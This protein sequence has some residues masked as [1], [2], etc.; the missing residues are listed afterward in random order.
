MVRSLRSVNILWSHYSRYWDLKALCKADGDNYCGIQ[1]SIDQCSLPSPATPLLCSLNIYHFMSIAL[2]SPTLIYHN[3]S[4]T[5]FI[6]HLLIYTKGRTQDLWVWGKDIS[7]YLENSKICPAPLPTLSSAHT[8]EKDQTRRNPWN[9]PEH[10][11]LPYWLIS[12]AFPLT[13]H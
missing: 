3:I 7:K 12:P 1:T 9:N 2:S 13:Y 6:N 11:L 8:I 4:P 10:L 5:I